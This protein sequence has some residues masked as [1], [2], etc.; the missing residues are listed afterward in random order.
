TPP[1]AGL[2]V[3]AGLLAALALRVWP[4]PAPQAIG[5]H[6]SP[7]MDLERWP[8]T[9]DPVWFAG[10]AALAGAATLAAGAWRLR[11]ATALPFPT[12]ALYAA[13]A[14][15]T[16]L[17]M[18]ALAYVRL[19]D[20]SPSMTLAAVA[21]GV[22]V[23]FAVLAARFREDED[24]D[25]PARR[26][27]AG[28]FASAAL[29]AIALGLTF[30]LEGG[31]L[32]VSL[33]L[34]ALGAAWTATRLDLPALRW[35]VAGLGVVIAARLAWEPRIVADLGK[36]PIFNWLLFGYGAP[37]LA[38][39]LAARLM[40]RAGGE[41]MPTRVAQSLA[42]LFSALLAFFEIR[43]L[44]N[45]G[46]AFARRSGL[47]EQ[48]LFATSAL[49]FALTL[50]RLDAARASPVFRIASFIAGGLA[51]LG[52][53]WGLGVLH[54]PLI[55]GRAVEGGA[56]LNGL[57]LGYLLPAILATALARGAEGVR[58]Y[59]FTLAAKLLAIGLLFGYVTLQTRRAFHDAQIGL[60]RGWS[61]GEWYAY[62]AI[63][64]GLGVALLA[65]G[66]WRGSREARL[67]SAGFVGLTVLKVF[68][69]DMSGLEGALRA[70]SFI[71][72][73][74]ALIGIGLVYQKLV[75]RRP[76]AEGS[77]L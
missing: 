9:V 74:L 42:I 34:A 33:S 1:G 27:G 17:A 13:G 55:S 32:T 73:G 44:I 57:L 67:A 62:S 2:L 36:T 24:R 47:V 69:L 70:A 53:V 77:V 16:P 49:A 56:A 40:R 51:A 15:L 8:P 26:L 61:D 19:T 38:F 45:D 21:A 5:P 37:A 54:N 60:L 66:L 22:G 46:D 4:A 65:W 52:V 3:G 63:W 18:L 68:L 58:P 11:R 43:H 25:A 20:R 71:G 6:W 23:A 14:A 28:A 7:G 39:G 30:A 59:A 72:L 12:L 64:L 31:A 29:A 48:G 50:T 75:F 76:P 10:F 41:D 35:C